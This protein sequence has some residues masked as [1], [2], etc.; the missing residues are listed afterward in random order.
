MVIAFIALGIAI[1]GTA[2]AAT[3][4]RNSV[5]ARQLRADA[6]RSSKV[7]DGS[8]RVRD[9]S[10]ATRNALRGPQGPQGAQG[11]QGPPGPAGG[12][13]GGGAAAVTITIAQTQGTVGPV[14]SDVA[15]RA[16]A[17]AQCP[18]GYKVTGGGVS[19]ANANNPEIAIGYSAP[20]GNGLSWTAAVDNDTSNPQTFTVYAVCAT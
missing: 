16:S 6:V 18:T 14:G 4:P 1:G 13:G 12:G 15:T 7:K 9:F 19:L 20:T 5:G 10:R 8:L 3:L 2:Y 11:P 17:T